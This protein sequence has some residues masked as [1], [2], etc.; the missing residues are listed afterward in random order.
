[1][2]STLEESTHL[3][4][5]ESIRLADMDSAIIGISECGRLIYDNEKIIDCLMAQG[6]SRPEAL[7][8]SDFNIYGSIPS[9]G[10]IILSV[11]IVT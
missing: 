8:W 2:V 1:M 3:L 10:C 9:G 11:R 5:E 7:D 4:N 6:M